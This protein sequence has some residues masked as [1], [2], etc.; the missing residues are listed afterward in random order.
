M[1][2][3][4]P[5]RVS[6]AD[7][8]LD[9][10]TVALVNRV[11]A[12]RHIA[13]TEVHFT[14]DL[15]SHPHQHRLPLPCETLSYELSGAAAATGFTPG[16]G[17]YFSLADFR[18]F[19]LSDTFPGQG[20]KA[21][22]PLGYHELPTGQGAGKRIV[23]HARTL[24]FDAG[25][26]VSQ[27]VTALPFGRHDAQGLKYEN[28]KLAFT[29]ELL[30][31][32]FGNKLLDEIRPGQTAGTLLAD[33]T[34]SGYAAGSQ[35]DA[36][37]A[38]QFW[39]RSGIA[40]FASDAA[41]QFYLPQTYTD[42]FGQATTLVYD[43]RHLFVQQSTDARGNTTTVE[44]F[45]HRVLAPSRLRDVN[46]NVSAIAFDAYGLP[47]ASAT[48]GKVTTDAAT[49]IE[50]A[51]TGDTVAGFA[52]GQL[53]PGV[54][55]VADFFT[56]AAFDEAQ[57]RR[58]L[59]QASARFVYHFGERRDAGDAVIAWSVSPASA[60]CLVREQ[61]EGALAN[62][63]LNNIPLQASFEYSDGAGQSFV[64]KLRAEP[65]SG[66]S[67]V[68]WIASGKTIVNN[69]GKPVLQYEP[70]F[71]EAGHRFEEP[72][73]VGVTPIMRYDAPG[74]LVR[75]DHPDGTVSRSEFS[76]WFSRAF[77]RNDTVLEPGNRWY[78][79]HSSAAADTQDQRAA[80]L[81]ALHAGTPSE[82]HF[83]SLGRDVLAI[84]HNR[85]PDDGNSNVPL[86]DRTWL[87]E[88]IVT[89]TQL[90]AEGKPLWVKDARGNL[91]MQYVSRAAPDPATGKTIN[92]VEPVAFV[93]CYDVAGNLLFQHSMD[94]GERWM[95]PDAAGKPMLAWDFNDFRHDDGS[96]TSQARLFH[97]HYDALQ[98]PL[99]Q[100]LR[101]NVA[102]AAQTEEFAYADTGGL[103]PTEL[104]AARAA[105]LIGRAVQ[106]WDTSGLASLEHVDLSG[107][108]ARATR[109]LLKPDVAGNANGVLDWSPPGRQALLDAETFI[110]LNEYDALGRVVLLYNWHRDQ[111]AGQS[112][113]VSVCQPAYNERGL[114]KAE[115]I[116]VRATKATAADGRVSFVA[117]P[118]RSV[119]AIK[120][121]GYDAKG[122][123]LRLDLGNG[124]VTRYAYDADTFRLVRLYTRRDVSF[125][126]DCGGD[127]P[128]PR[129]AAPD[130]DRPPRSCGVQNLRYTYDPAG[131]VTHVQDDA[132]Q[133]IWFNGQRI[134]PSNDYLYDA[135]YRLIE[136]TGRE[137]GAATAPPPSR[138]I[139]YAPS[140]IPSGALLATYAQRY[141]YDSVGNFLQ[142]RH[143]AKRVA[144]PQGAG[145]WTRYHA[146]ADDSNRLRRTWYGDPDW[147]STAAS[148]KTEYRHDPHGSMLNLNRMPEDWGLDICWD[149][150]DMMRS[151]D[152]GGGG[153]AHY[154]YA[155]NKHRTRKYIIRNGGTTED[156]I[157][158]GGY[159]LYRRSR[160]NGVVEEIETHHLF[161]REQRVLLVDD[162]LRADAAGPPGPNGLRV[163]EQTLFRYQYGNHLG[164]V[165][166][167]LD[168]QAKVISYEEYRPYGATAHRCAAAS[169]EA[170]ARRYRYIGMERD[171]ESGLG[172]HN[173]RYLSSALARWL[174]CDPKLLVDGVNVYR[175]ARSNPVSLK[176]GSGYASGAPVKGSDIYKDLDALKG[177]IREH[178]LPGAHIKRLLGEK[179][180]PKHVEKIMGSL[181]RRMETILLRGDIA[182]IK[183]YG[184]F[185]S[186][187]I[188]TLMSDNEAT[189]H[190]K[191]FRKNPEKIFLQTKQRMLAA[192]REAGGNLSA[193]EIARIE[194][195]ITTNFHQLIQA[196]NIFDH[197]KTVAARKNGIRAIIPGVA[198]ALESGKAAAALLASS[199]TAV[200]VIKFGK[201]ITNL[202]AG[203][204]IIGLTV[205]TTAN[206]ASTG[207][208]QAKAGDS[209]GAASTG[210]L[211][212]VD[213]AA[214][215]PT[216][217]GK[218]AASLQVGMAAG[219]IMDAGLDLQKAAFTAGDSTEH[220]VQYFGGSKESASIAGGVAS[221]L[222]AIADGIQLLMNPGAL[223][224]R[225]NNSIT[226]F[227]S[228]AF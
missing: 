127:P 39:M 29:A 69:K 198:K 210:F 37:L 45:D 186:G 33:P 223:T 63:A 180:D 41:S 118:A 54:G 3:V 193:K 204:L 82:T 10:A 64:K 168:Q 115:Q 151:F 72:V 218:V 144:G 111:T 55:A 136:A 48:M 109:R 98:R 95:L 114:L 120:A 163:R 131:N 94:A 179:F 206:A 1:A 203:G 52:F 22:L 209:K 5:R 116:H 154:H 27:P 93:P 159:E 56:G 199:K 162:V 86:T 60:C 12:K 49:G 143:T 74:R 134:E 158:L 184:K 58:W 166:A 68:R 205:A 89:F 38:G 110:H 124:T 213:V 172:Y 146:V 135:T 102:P 103:T 176:D 59:G 221:S 123:K 182:D 96:K 66:S 91:V 188:Q 19:A 85:S 208:E 149:W 11:Q 97:T 81:A 24:Y 53:N 133:T 132:Q 51:Q 119:Q 35:I 147:F 4:Y 30:D 113:R 126:Q 20:A 195:V 224:N 216:P 50:S 215:T 62:V 65:A 77:D 173:A 15:P 145:S 153:V 211:T 191:E 142:M 87:D 207:Y 26:G 106:H 8:R 107:H 44:A 170:P 46:G 125:G 226:Q 161:E 42:L 84:A 201:G 150:R 78:A 80:R 117:D 83:D 112:E 71:S 36:T 34:A 174:S 104:V 100:W 194:D 189:A 6:F 139:P 212:A 164:S 222:G 156:R 18:A 155:V 219:E 192:I 47:V 122:Q 2:V 138:D 7:S 165:S 90:D 31:A 167:E 105:N 40:G 9:A 220:A 177:Y 108:A 76:P 61:H 73:P 23:E 130:T 227:I 57:A 181:Y 129:T 13:Y 190:W 43:A 17:S 25:P 140:S 14:A 157:Y 183:T 99:S 185:E 187:G 178:V 148:D 217:V 141:L 70:Y 28:Y 228:Q 67:A 202:V 160:A 214:Q 92:Q 121:I 128:P 137:S 88:R 171:E 79:E 16:T 101:V 225:I 21:V 196:E 197:V 175:Y 169:V 200:A 75:T 32:V 152:L